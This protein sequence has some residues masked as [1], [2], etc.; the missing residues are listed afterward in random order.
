MG[1]RGRVLTRHVDVRLYRLRIYT[2]KRL[3][4]KPKTSCY[5]FFLQMLSGYL[6]WD[7]MMSSPHTLFTNMH[8][9]ISFSLLLYMLIVHSCYPWA[10][11]RNLYSPLLYYYPLLK[12][13]SINKITIL[14]R[15]LKLL[16][17]LNH[18]YTWDHLFWLF[19]IRTHNR[20]S[21]YLPLYKI[22]L[23][24]LC[25]AWTELWILHPRLMK[26]RL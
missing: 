1:W 23:H 19:F 26:I 6:T 12:L 14:L 10:D 8:I 25:C 16:L 22:F 11:V 20:S 4:W 7:H 3:G 13:L 18:S 5:P 2:S 17:L 9:N 15:L 21:T 24:L